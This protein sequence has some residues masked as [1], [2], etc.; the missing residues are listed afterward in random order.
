VTLG[1][2]GWL[3]PLRLH[4]D[5]TP[6]EAVGQTMQPRT[7]TEVRLAR[8]MVE[9][10]VKPERIAVTADFW[11][12]NEGPAT[13]LDVGFPCGTEQ[14]PHDLRV[15]E[16]NKELPVTVRPAWF[17]WP[18]AFAT[19]EEKRLRVTYWQR[20]TWRPWTSRLFRYILHTGAA[21]KGPIGQATIRVHFSQ[22]PRVEPL[23]A[24][25]SS[26]QFDGKT[27][28][29]ELTNFEPDFDLALRWKERL[30][31]V[32]TD[33][34]IPQGEEADLPEDLENLPVRVPER[35]TVERRGEKA[36]LRL[37]EE[38]ISVEVRDGQRQAVVDGTPWELRAA[39]RMDETGV[40]VPLRL[41]RALGWVHARYFPAGEMLLIT[42][43]G[44]N[45]DRAAEAPL[46]GWHRA[47]RSGTLDE[48]RRRIHRLERA[49]RK[50]P[51]RLFELGEL[52]YYL[53]DVDGAGPSF[54]ACARRAGTGPLADLA[55]F[56]EAQ[57][58]A[59][60]DDYRAAV[61]ALEQVVD[62]TTDA[63]LAQAARVQAATWLLDHEDLYLLPP[64]QDRT[65]RA[66]QLA[67]E[68]WAAGPVR[69]QARNGEECPPLTRPSVPLRGLLPAAG[70][71]LVRCDELQG[72]LKQAMERLRA[73]VE[74]FPDDPQL[75]GFLIEWWRGHEDRKV[76]E[77]GL[78]LLTQH[79]PDRPQTQ[80]A[81]LTY[82]EQ[83]RP[84]G[85]TDPRDADWS[86]RTRRWV[87]RTLEA[88]TG[89]EAETL[90]FR[91]WARKWLGQG[92]S[93]LEELDL[94]Q[95]E[96]RAIP[97]QHQ[98]AQVYDSLLNELLS[99][100][101]FVQARGLI[102]EVQARWPEG[103]YWTRSWQKDVAVAEGRVDEALAGLQQLLRHDVPAQIS[104]QQRSD[105]WHAETV[106]LLV[107]SGRV[108]AAV[109]WFRELHA[110][111]RETER[112]Y[113][114]E[115][116]IPPA[117]YRAGG[118]ALLAEDGKNPAGHILAT[119][120]ELPEFDFCTGTVPALIPRLEKLTVRY[121]REYLAW[122]GL[123][124]AYR[125]L[126][127]KNHPHY[128]DLQQ[129]YAERLRAGRPLPSRDQAFVDR[130]ERWRKGL[131]D[132]W[133]RALALN[134]D[135]PEVLARSFDLLKRHGGEKV[136]RDLQAAAAQW[137]EEYLRQHPEEVQG[138]WALVWFKNRSAGKA[139]EMDSL[140]A[141]REALLRTAGWALNRGQAALSPLWDD[142]DLL[143]Q[144]YRELGREPELWMVRE[145]VAQQVGTK[146]PQ[147]PEEVTAAIAR[148]EPQ[149]LYGSVSTS[150]ALKLGRLYERAGRFQ[151]AARA[152]RLGLVRGMGDKKDLRRALEALPP[153]AWAPIPEPGR[154]V[155]QRWGWLA[156]AGLLVMAAWIGWR[157]CQARIC[158]RR[159]PDSSGG[160]A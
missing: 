50:T 141:C 18:M 27:V 95:R 127:S 99:H 4:A 114:P 9:A 159:A 69:S 14:P 40:Q 53:G 51:E 117:V 34:P 86:T 145:W 57:C 110:S 15:W 63:N 55:R 93:P 25:P 108:G 1:L 65:G 68:V 157:R 146:E 31:I 101:D 13:T 100:R 109:Q 130:F 75:F 115:Y 84:P 54:A 20:R 152:Y 21:W 23:W 32:R 124:E 132:C 76:R 135:S 17:V 126:Y 37:D 64:G 102:R 49:W 158:S 140:R 11:L 41:L 148:L 38:G 119:L 90:R 30:S 111:A 44:V 139:E 121:P 77:A 154:P 92:I 122:F 156:A 78:D 2:G 136:D 10:E 147:T 45:A 29:W 39:P 6:F 125:L 62:S 129:A 98:A 5:A 116:H 66:R 112:R 12:R 103:S 104:A 97:D 16:G 118:H 26:Y 134:P 71:L 107:Q 35:V 113:F 67:E 70:M 88:A 143:A 52:R 24:V 48:Y 85:K 138:W 47:P 160:E 72:Q 94:R 33:R 3:F 137:V 58:L 91:R 36:K 150:E 56:W 83:T 7:A 59:H 123:G 142:V 74:R 149:V 79:F 22:V 82:L 131:V 73:S 120:A 19:E 128:V 43:W 60:R 46:A 8:E 89:E 133:S 96:A 153:K 42:T 61:A 80:E 87:E 105:T 81:V 151:E 144:Q 28:T 106:E 155:W